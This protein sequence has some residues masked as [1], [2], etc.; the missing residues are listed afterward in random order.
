[1][2]NVH[3]IE[4]PTA[5]VAIW[6]DDGIPDAPVIAVDVDYPGRDHNEPVFIPASI[7]REVAA[8]ILASVP[9]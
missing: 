9:E 1:M 6:H 8:A 5:P 7:A 4:H 2:T 3:V